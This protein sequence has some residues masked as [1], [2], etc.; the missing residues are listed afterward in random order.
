MMIAVITVTAGV[1]EVTA[2]KISFIHLKKKSDP[3][4]CWI[5][6]NDAIGYTVC[7]KTKTKALQNFVLNVLRMIPDFSA[8]SVAYSQLQI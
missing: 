5:L 4:N 1:V 6:L 3:S 7:Q 8:T 2:S